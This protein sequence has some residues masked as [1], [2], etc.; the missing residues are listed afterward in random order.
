MDLRIHV[1][2]VMFEIGRNHTKPNQTPHPRRIETD[3]RGIRRVTG[4][5][6]ALGDIKTTKVVNCGGA[7]ARR[8]G[9][10]VG[11]N[12]PLCAMV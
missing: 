12:V 1:S 2:L 6:T 10:M 4:V 11:V 7:W 9:R 3:A 5:R 8:I